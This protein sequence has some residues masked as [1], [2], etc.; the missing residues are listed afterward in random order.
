MR[1]SFRL[2]AVLALTAV[3]AVNLVDLFAKPWR[4][5]RSKELISRAEQAICYEQPDTAKRL[6]AAAEKVD[7]DYLAERR[8]NVLSEQDRVLADHDYARQYYNRCGN[9]NRVAIIDAVEATYSSPKAALDK[10]LELANQGETAYAQQL[11]S[12]A[13]QMN[14]DYAGLKVARNILP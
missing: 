11:V 3:L 10:A 6:L 1:I 4:Q 7:P 2:L 8:A 5:S 12:L 9:T 14:P 13:E